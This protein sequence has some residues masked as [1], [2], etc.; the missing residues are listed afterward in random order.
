[1]PADVEVAI[2]ELAPGGG[3]DGRSPFVLRILLFLIACLIAV[4]TPAH[5]QPGPRL[6][7]GFIGYPAES[8]MKFQID[9]S[10]RILAS[11]G[12]ESGAYVAYAQRSFWDIDDD[13]RPFRV[14]NDFRPEVG[15]ACGAD[16]GRRMLSAWPDDLALSAAF[17]HESNGLEQ[18]SSRG[19]NRIV[20]GIHL[21][22]RE[23]GF[24]VLGWHAFRVEDTNAEITRDAGD[25]ELRVRADLSRLAPGTSLRVRSAFSTDARS[26]HFFTN[27]E[28][29]L[30]LW[31]T[32]LP[33]WLLPGDEGPPVDLVLEWFTGTGEFLY[34][35][36]EHTN[37]VGL[38]ITLHPGSAGWF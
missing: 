28:V 3:R 4:T 12:G 14:E 30:Y 18:E 36:D 1:V 20:G 8:A 33:D 29:G 26:G 2:E 21:Q 5:A 11:P 25:G 38:G 27:L 16:L 15:V 37:H 35:Y 13:D 7:T 31:P 6:P 23:I 34:G 9:L 10:L 24:S 32:F 19:W 22:A 17:V